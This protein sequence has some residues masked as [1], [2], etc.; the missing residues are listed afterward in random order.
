MISTTWAAEQFQ[1]AALKAQ[2][3]TA[4]QKFIAQK[5]QERKLAQAKL[6]RG[7]SPS[8]EELRSDFEAAANLTN[9]QIALSVDEE[10]GPAELEDLGRPL[11]HLGF[12]TITLVY[13]KA[14]ITGDDATHPT[15]EVRRSRLEDGY[16]KESLEGEKIMHA[17]F[18]GK[19]RFESF[20]AHTQ[21]KKGADM[22]V[23]LFEVSEIDNAKN[24]ECEIRP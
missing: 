5:K 9:D 1:Y 20:M 16:R 18:G 22:V 23:S 17:M 15:F 10:L 7:L 21:E 19:K 8:E 4:R 24:P 2:R 3:E 14:G 6:K 11:G 13:V 12:E